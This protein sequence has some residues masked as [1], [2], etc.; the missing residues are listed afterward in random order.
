MNEL[1]FAQKTVCELYYDNKAA[2][3]ISRNPV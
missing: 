1:G 3:S 2:I